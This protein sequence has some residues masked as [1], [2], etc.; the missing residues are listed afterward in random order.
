MTEHRCPEFLADGEISNP[1]R[2]EATSTWER[3]IEHDGE[4]P[5]NQTIHLA[6]FACR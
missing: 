5:A 3:D 4:C 6:N 1:I 2:V